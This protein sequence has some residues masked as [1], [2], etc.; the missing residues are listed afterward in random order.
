MLQQHDVVF[1]PSINEDLAATAIW[2]TQLTDHYQTTS[3]KQGVFGYWYGK[4]HG[5]DRSADVFR[6]ANI[7][8]TAKFGGAL[9]IAGDDHN[10]ESSVFAHQTDHIFAA[11]LMPLL[12]PASIEEYVR[13]GLAGIALSRFSGLWVGF[14]AVTEVIESAGSISQ[15]ML[16]T[17]Q[18][19][20]LV[21]P[22]HGLNFDPDLQWP[23]QRGEYERRVLE[24][25]IPAAQA[26]AYANEL[27]VTVA[28]V[29][30]GGLGIVT[31]GKGYTDL[32]QA[33]ADLG[34]ELS[35]L[36]QAGVGVLK[37]G[38]IWPL[39]PRRIGEFARGAKTLFVIEEKRSFLEDQVKSAFTA[40][41]RVNV[42]MLWVRSVRTVV[43]CW[44]NP[45]C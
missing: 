30:A 36:S 26:F 3:R 13:F 32:L 23:A 2:G 40:C 29:E 15:S 11:T 1:Q 14:K 8:G 44:R 12:F 9:V 45:A 43:R 33:L 20:D 5:V 42:L 21:R 18:T 38:M 27:D 22:I 24:E 31:A 28:R 35:D 39:E 4:G 17:F 7:Q 37:I 25:R 34:L 41:R 10:A 16:P 19:P 6:Q